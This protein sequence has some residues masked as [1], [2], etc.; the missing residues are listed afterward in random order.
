MGNNSPAHHWE[1]Y[2]QLDCYAG[3][4]GG[5]P[6]VTTLATTVCD[7]LA[8]LNGKN[9]QASGVTFSGTNPNMGLFAPDTDLEP[10]RERYISTTFVWLHA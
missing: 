4:S 9:Y 6:E 5:V 1:F 10:A 7:A 2:F 8:E 3:S